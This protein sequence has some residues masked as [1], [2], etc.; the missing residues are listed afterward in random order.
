M[1]E[2]RQRRTEHVGQVC[3]GTDADEEQ[4]HEQRTELE[5]GRDVANDRLRKIRDQKRQCSHHE[6]EDRLDAT[7]NLDG[8][9]ERTN[10]SAGISINTNRKK[11]AP[12]ASAER[13]AT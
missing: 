10:G 7:K 9:A 4:V 8:M 5:F 1:Q 3:A 12:A 6:D 13:P 2:D 11:T